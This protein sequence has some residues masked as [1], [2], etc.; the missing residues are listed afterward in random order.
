MDKTAVLLVDVQRD[1][2]A[3]SGPDRKILTRR[4][5]PFSPLV[6]RRRLPVSIALDGAKKCRF[7]ALDISGRRGGEVPCSFDEGVLSFMA[8]TKGPD[9]KGVLAWEISR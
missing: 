4:G 5:E 6:E 7:H 2:V 8:D 3:Y 1:G 9:G